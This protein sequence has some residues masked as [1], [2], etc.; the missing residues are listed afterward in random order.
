MPEGL[1]RIPRQYH[2][3]VRT[4]G[5]RMGSIGAN[6][7]SKRPRERCTGS[8]GGIAVIALIRITADAANSA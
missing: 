5:V 6:T 1:E 4:D 7:T 8:S 3:V 2:A